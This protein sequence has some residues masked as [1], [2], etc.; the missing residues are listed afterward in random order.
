MKKFLIGLVIII[1]L[2]QIAVLNV[3]ATASSQNGVEQAFT[4]VQQSINDL[5][6]AKD[7]NNSNDVGLRIE[8]FKKVLSLSVSETKDLKIKLLSADVGNNKALAAWQDTMAQALDGVLIYY[9]NQGQNLDQLNNVD[10]ATIKGLASN[11]KDWR[12]KNYLPL[13]EQINDFILIQGEKNAINVAEKRSQK[14]GTDIK[15]LPTF[16]GFDPAALLEGANN[17]I[18]LSKQLNQNAYD[19]FINNF[20][21]IATTT[22]SSTNAATS[23]TLPNTASTTDGTVLSPIVLSPEGTASTTD[24]NAS[25]T[26]NATSSDVNAT[27]TEVS[28]LPVPSIKDLIKASLDKIKDAYQIFIEMSNQVRQLLG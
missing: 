4:A 18:K 5:I 22:A 28:P 11:F 13:A 15:K 14:I 8:A 12:D 20:I 24:Q 9:N 7:Q 25:T 21:N 19:A 2:S 17:D 3:S 10:L 16:N 27:S 26:L 23:S 6:T 1:G